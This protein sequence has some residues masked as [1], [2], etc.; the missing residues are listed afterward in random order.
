LKHGFYSPNAIVIDKD[1]IERIALT[2]AIL[3]DALC[4]EYHKSGRYKMK[5]QLLFVLVSCQEGMRGKLAL[6]IAQ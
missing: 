2:K 1:K 3:E 5:C 6:Q 4:W